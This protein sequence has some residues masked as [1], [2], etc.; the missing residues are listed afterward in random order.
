[1]KSVMNIFLQK[2]TVLRQE[3]QRKELL[4]KMHSELFNSKP[5]TTDLNVVGRMNL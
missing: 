1:M 5:D 4:E 2:A 3:K